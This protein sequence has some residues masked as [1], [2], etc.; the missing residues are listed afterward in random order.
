M[1]MTMNGLRVIP[2]APFLSW[3]MELNMSEILMHRPWFLLK[4]SIFSGDISLLCGIYG[5][6]RDKAGDWPI[7]SSILSGGSRIQPIKDGEETTS[8]P[9][10]VHVVYSS[11]DESLAGVEASIKSVIDHASGPVAFH[12]VGNTPYRQFRVQMYTSRTY[13]GWPG[14]TTWTIT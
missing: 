12:Y 1:T 5:C 8:S 9:K 6:F 7:P 11:D 10:A 3:P 4:M 14:S 2:I 13:R